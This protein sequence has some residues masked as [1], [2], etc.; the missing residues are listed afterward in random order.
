MGNS[1]NVI[2]CH[3]EDMTQNKG[4]NIHKCLI[5]YFYLNLTNGCSFHV[6]W[7]MSE[8][9][10]VRSYA[11]VGIHTKASFHPAS[12]IEGSKKNYDIFQGMKSHR[13]ALL[14]AF[15]RLNVL[16]TCPL[17]DTLS[18]RISIWEILSAFTAHHFDCKII[19]TFK[20]NTFHFHVARRPPVLFQKEWM[21]ACFN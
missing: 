16:P 4:N 10:F 19:L 17:L 14:L 1:Q 9:A 21:S 7:G 3:A 12:Y 15:M 5:V 8:Y 6:K 11:L 13:I 2:N 18:P 20:R